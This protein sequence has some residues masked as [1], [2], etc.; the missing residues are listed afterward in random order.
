MRGTLIV[1]GGPDGSGKTT[2]A[3]MLLKYFAMKKLRVKVVRIRGTHTLAYTLM[4]FL[5]RFSV[6]K[7]SGLHYYSFRVPPKLKGLWLVIELLSI[8]PLIALYYYVYRLVYDVV[9]SERGALD[10]AVW[11]LTGVRPRPSSLF[12]RAFLKVAQSLI[13]H[14]KTIYIT[15][16][17]ETLLKR[18]LSER[19][20]ISDMY[21]IYELLAKQL[22]LRRIDTTNL[23]P[24]KAFRELLKVLREFGLVV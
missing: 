21:C 12:L 19:D 3:L 20:L 10:F 17:K 5:R 1:L 11:V 16:S 14:F 4:V 22:Y 6:F 24:S 7:G 8:F 13:L 15:A 23:Q 2:L 9:I 18:K